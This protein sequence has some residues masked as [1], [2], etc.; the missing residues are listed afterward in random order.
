VCEGTPILVTAACRQRTGSVRGYCLR[1]ARWRRRRRRR[2]GPLFCCYAGHHIVL[3]TDHTPLLGRKIARRSSDGKSVGSPD[4]RRNVPWLDWRLHRANAGKPRRN[5]RRM[6]HRVR[7]SESLACG[8]TSPGSRDSSVCPPRAW[9]RLRT[10]S[11]PSNAAN[12]M[13]TTGLHISLCIGTRPGC[14]MSKIWQY[15]TPAHGAGSSWSRRQQS[16]TP[17][18]RR[19]I[20]FSLRVRFRDGRWIVTIGA[21][22]DLGVVSLEQTVHP[23]Q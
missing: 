5:A 8:R 18:V 1:Q 23:L 19:M 4:C 11:S 14:M 7:L 20:H 22:L 15:A 9:H 16:G 3:Q 2:R 12:A 10:S 17:Q 13:P 21:V 6:P